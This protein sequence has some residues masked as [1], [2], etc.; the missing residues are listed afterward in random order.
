MAQNINNSIRQT[1]QVGLQFL[2]RTD[3]KGNEIEAFG[4]VRALLIGIAEGRLTV[5]A[6]GPAANDPA[7]E[8]PAR[9]RRNGANTTSET[10]SQA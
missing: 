2:A 8:K 9:A 7:L 3:L 10:P 4:A 6:V 1:A 5:T